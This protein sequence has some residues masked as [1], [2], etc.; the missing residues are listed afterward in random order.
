MSRVRISTTVDGDRLRRCRE[1]L[2]VPDSQLVDAALR[3]LYDSLVARAEIEALESMPYE[4]DPDLAWEAPLGPDLP[5]DGE[6][7]DDVLEL[8]RRRRTS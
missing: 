8:A 4:D 5:Y 6:V 2:E 1:L 3:A 7:P